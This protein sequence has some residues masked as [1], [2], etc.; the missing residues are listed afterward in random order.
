MRKLE[1]INGVPLQKA[2]KMVDK[3]MSKI[4]KPFLTA[5][6]FKKD[7]KVV[8]KS[9]CRMLERSTTG[10][11]F[12]LFVAYLLAN[13]FVVNVSP[14]D[15]HNALLSLS[16][17]IAHGIVTKGSALMVRK[18][19]NRTQ[20][21]SLI[22]K[23]PELLLVYVS[24]EQTAVEIM[25][26]GKAGVSFITD[27][28]IVRFLMILLLDRYFDIYF[29]TIT[30]IPGLREEIWSSLRS[31]GINNRMWEEI[32]ESWQEIIHNKADKQVPIVG[33]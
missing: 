24:T 18:K 23:R 11:R 10:S 27:E 19:Y 7:M 17:E 1:Q 33:C 9:F 5:A 30:A 20:I 28:D 13:R 26:L 21:Q 4:G 16:K 29:T 32:S 12:G 2:Q 6:R 8:K 15:K 25:K 14:Q 31:F 3:I 22:R